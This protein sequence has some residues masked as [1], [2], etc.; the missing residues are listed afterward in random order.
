MNHLEILN[1]ALSMLKEKGQLYGPEDDLHEDISKIAT[2]LLNKS[3]SPYD[4]AMIH[5]A[6]KLT[7]IKNHRNHYDSYID[8]VN[9]LSFAGQFVSRTDSVSVALEDGLVKMTRFPYPNKDDGSGETNN[10]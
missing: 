2:I 1:N 10:D 4:V 6:T 8:A 7:R 5:V 3:I 9:Y